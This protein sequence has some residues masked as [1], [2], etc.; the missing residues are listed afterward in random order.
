MDGSQS[1]AAKTNNLSLFQALIPV[2]VLVVILA[3]NVYVYGDDALSG[4]NQF[5]LL[6]GGAVAAIVGFINNVSYNKMLEKV[7]KNMLDQPNKG[8][9]YTFDIGDIESFQKKLEAAVAEKKLVDFKFS[10]RSSLGDIILPLLPFIIIVVIWIF[11]MRRMSGAGGG[12]GGGGCAA[13]G[14]RGAV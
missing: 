12:A 10:Q 6:I 5:I 11:V 4:S 8:P 14:A 9:H 2:V 1:T 13:L 3:F 7:S